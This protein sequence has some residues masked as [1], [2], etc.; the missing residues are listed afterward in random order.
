MKRPTP[1]WGGPTAVPPNFRLE[2]THGPE[3]AGQ[4]S[5]LAWNRMNLFRPPRHGRRGPA[6]PTEVKS[7]PLHPKGSSHL[8]GAR[9]EGAIFRRPPPARLLTHPWLAVGGVCRRTHLPHRFVIGDSSMRRKSVNMSRSVCRRSVILSPLKRP[10]KMSPPSLDEDGRYADLVA[11]SHTASHGFQR[12]RARSTPGGRCRHP[13]GTIRSADAAPPRCLPPAGCRR[14]R[15]WQ[16][17]P[18]FA[19]AR[20]RHPPAAP[21]ALGADD[22]RGGELP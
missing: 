14:A 6:Q 9:L 12:P 3:N 21:R 17:G 22:L 16:S 2:P 20:A 7:P 15:A 5:A 18:T 11:T 13:P 19:R 8:F 10:V 4:N 1:L